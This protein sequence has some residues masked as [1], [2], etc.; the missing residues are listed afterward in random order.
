MLWDILFIVFVSSF[1]MHNFT[2]DRP[3]RVTCIPL[4]KLRPLAVMSDGWI[5]DF[6][7]QSAIGKLPSIVSYSSSSSTIAFTTH[8]YYALP[9]QNSPSLEHHTS[10]DAKPTHPI[11]S[12]G[13][14]TVV[15]HQVAAYRLV[16]SKHIF[17]VKTESSWK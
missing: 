1:A 2:C 5:H 16:I 10:Q 6:R 7:T 17:L 15:P 4:V 11:S 13:I 9:R 8:I 3:I 14:V 12:F